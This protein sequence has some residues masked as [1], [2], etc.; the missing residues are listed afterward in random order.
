MRSAL[1]FSLLV[2]ALNAC[3]STGSK[4]ASCDPLPTD[5]TY[6]GVTPAYRACAVDQRVR[7]LTTNVNPD[8]RPQSMPAPSTGCYK[9]EVEFVVGPTGIPELGTARVVHAAPPEFGTALLAMV[10]QLRYEPARKAGV[11]VRQIQRE[12]REA[13]YAVVVVASPNSPRPPARRPNC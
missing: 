7:L 9:A 4:T 10:Q 2:S 1:W 3:A 12:Q 8:F 5:S 11:P 13:A 6:Q